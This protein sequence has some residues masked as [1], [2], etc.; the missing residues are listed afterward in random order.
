MDIN[1]CCSGSSGSTLLSHI[2]NRHSQVFCGEELGMFSKNIFYENFNYLQ[3]KLF[4]ISRYGIS[5]NPYF[6]D[7]TI[8]RNLKYFGLEKDVIWNMLKNSASFYDFSKRMKKII[9]ENT[10]KKFWAEKTPENIYTIKYFINEFQNSKIVHIV[11]DP[12]DVVL[13]LMKRGFSLEEAGDIWLSSVS[14]IQPFVD[15][16]NIYEIRY[17]DLVLNPEREI[18][19]LCIFLELEYEETLLEKDYQVNK[20]ETFFDSW[21]NE[22]N[23][24]ISTSSLKKYKNSNQNFERLYSMKVTYDFAKLQNIK[25]YYLLDL[26]EQYGYEIEDI[27]IVKIKQQKKCRY[28]H[29]NNKTWKEI[30]LNYLIEQNNEMSRIELSCVE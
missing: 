24:K 13:S 4:L 14:S 21:E 18:K 11:R 19:K 28:H 2:I 27:N 1:I 30:L 29:S 26:M 7:K 12:R 10:G 15:N 3:E 17:E 6:S 5:S 22:P 25:E 8:L 16:K 20:R 9:L 23:S